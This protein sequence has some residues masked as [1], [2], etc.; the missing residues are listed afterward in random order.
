MTVSQISTEIY[1]ILRL[2]NSP[3][4][5]VDLT[6]VDVTSVAR[7]DED[8]LVDT[9][10]AFSCPSPC[11]VV[12]DCGITRATLS[13]TGLMDIFEIRLHTY[14]LG[15]YLYLLAWPIPLLTCF[16][17]TSTYLITCWAYT[18]TYLLDLY[19]YLLAWLIPLL[20][21]WYNFVRPYVVARSS[22]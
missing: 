13:R 15:L 22:E 21:C 11:R 17:Y 18:Y 12:R 1:G 14:L 9:C 2:L 3:K 4:L 6:F 7:E 5:V 10:W 19:L 16:A 8:V 20:T